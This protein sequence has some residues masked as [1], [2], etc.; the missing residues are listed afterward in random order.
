MSK[1]EFDWSTLTRNDLINF[2]YQL[3]PEIANKELDVGYFH[4]T[5]SNYI[6]KYIPVKISKKKDK[7]VPFNKI[8]MGGTY[9]SDYDKENKKCIEI[10]FLYNSDMPYLKLSSKKIKSLSK[11]FADTV[12]HE[13][14]HMR[15]HRRRKFKLL[16]EY[17]SNAEKTEKRHEQSYLG[18]S[19]EIDAYGF[20]IACEM[21][22]KFKGKELSIVK[23]LNKDL[24]KSRIKY[25]TWRMYLRAFD[26]DHKHVI[27]KRL[28]KKIIR[29]LPYAK[30]GKPYRNKDWINW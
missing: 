30:L 25:D 5:V 13:V 8:F 1:I 23:Y 28:K 9:Y 11:S 18:S 6:K 17:E 24:K 21:N 26:Y 7:Q 15:Q 29:Y 2:L 16:P 10:V 22:E 12:L 14:I 27:I 3:S 19:D 20:N 4:T